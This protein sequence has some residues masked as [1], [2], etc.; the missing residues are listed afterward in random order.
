MN[1]VVL[2][3]VNISVKMTTKKMFQNNTADGETIE[4]SPDGVIGITITNG[5][6]FKQHLENEDKKP[7]KFVRVMTVAA[8]LLC[9]SL[10]GIM[11]SLYYLFLWDPKIRD[12][13]PYEYPKIDHRIHESNVHH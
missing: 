9:V 1:K 4:K 2:K 10:A 5:M 12:E 7:S 11:L 8:Y 13:T 6:T 3:F